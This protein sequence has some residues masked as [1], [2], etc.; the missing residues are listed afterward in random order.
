MMLKLPRTRARMHIYVCMQIGMNGGHSA[1]AMLHASPSLTVH[2]FDMMNW[3]YSWPVVR[4]LSTTFSQRFFIHPGD[5]RQT[6]PQ[7]ASGWTQQRRAT[8]TRHATS[9]GPCD[10]ILVD[11]DHTLKGAVADL[12]NMR[13]A[14]ARKIVFDEVTTRACVTGEA[15]LTSCSG[16]HDRSN[17]EWVARG[18]AHAV[19]A[20][21]NFSREGGM[22]VEDCI[23]V[24]K[25]KNDGLCW[26]SLIPGA[27]RGVD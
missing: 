12:R 17:A 23:W 13:A 26:G 11:G 16:S 7:W 1:A 14:G 27:R 2:S 22:R 20:Y 24:P 6:V 15:E 10:L 4:L 8:R 18:Y 19:A 3:N 25:Y 9:A 5:S 21:H